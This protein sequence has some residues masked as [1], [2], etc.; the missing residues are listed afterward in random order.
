MKFLQEVD[1]MEEEDGLSD[2]EKS[3]DKEANIWYQQD[4]GIFEAPFT[5]IKSDGRR[6]RYDPDTYEF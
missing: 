6:V 5:L 2:D 1:Q 3:W 4:E